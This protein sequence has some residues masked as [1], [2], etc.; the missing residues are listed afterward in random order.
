[1]FL[2]CGQLGGPAQQLV[3]LQA[4]FQLLLYGPGVTYVPEDPAEGA[5]LGIEHEE[6][7]EAVYLVFA[8]Q[9]LV[10]ERTD[11]RSAHTGNQ[12]LPFL[13]GSL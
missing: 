2:L 9:H 7:G 8:A 3:C 10:R 11:R 4:G 1:L 12:S 6:G 5:P 13:R